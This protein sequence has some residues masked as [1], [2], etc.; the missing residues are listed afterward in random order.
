MVTMTVNNKLDLEWE[1]GNSDCNETPYD[2]QSLKKGGEKPLGLA[3]NHYRMLHG[4]ILMPCG[5]NSFG[6]FRILA[7]CWYKC[8]YNV[9]LRKH[10]LS[11]AT[12]EWIYKRIPVGT[13][14]DGSRRKASF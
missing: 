3:E 7:L 10:I 12:T 9:S 1:P 8:D 13:L 4:K 14:R 11:I 6:S 2:V 5:D